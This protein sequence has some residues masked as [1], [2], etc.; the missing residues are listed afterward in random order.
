MEHT[1]HHS[2]HH[3]ATFQSAKRIE[4]EREKAFHEQ[5]AEMKKADLQVRKSADSLSAEVKRLPST[6]DP[7][8]P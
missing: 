3:E 7:H 4:A 6:L 5:V 2:G 8:P 1:P